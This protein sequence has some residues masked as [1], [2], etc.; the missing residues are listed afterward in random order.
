MLCIFHFIF[1]V[2]WAWFLLFYPLLL[3]SWFMMLIWLTGSLW[4]LLECYLIMNLL[5]LNCL[6]CYVSH[7]RQG[8]SHIVLIITIMHRCLFNKDHRQVPTPLTQNAYCFKMVKLE[9]AHIT[10]AM[11]PIL[12]VEVKCYVKSFVTQVNH[13]SCKQTYQQVLLNGHEKTKTKTS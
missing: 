3:S 13:V 12:T 8:V 2:L 1:L 10:C 9:M 4:S 5:C 6:C 11:I 7:V